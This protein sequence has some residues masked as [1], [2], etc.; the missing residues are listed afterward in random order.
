MGFPPHLQT[1]DSPPQSPVGSARD[2]DS[3]LRF[4]ESNMAKFVAVSSAHAFFR[5]LFQDFP[6]LHGGFHRL[7]TALQDG[8]QINTT[9]DGSKISS[10]EA[11]AGWMFWLRVDA[12]EESDDDTCEEGTFSFVA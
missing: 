5:C 8:V 9:S 1:G 12:D 4:C 2:F 3:F 6:V 10:G 7:L 11:S